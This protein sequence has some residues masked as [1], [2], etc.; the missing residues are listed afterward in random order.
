M[1]HPGLPGHPGLPP[2]PPTFAAPAVV[3][4]GAAGAGSGVFTMFYHEF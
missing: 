1:T 3:G 4:M 2:P